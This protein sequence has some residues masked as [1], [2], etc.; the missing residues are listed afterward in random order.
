MPE[1]AWTTT[2]E[3]EQRPPGRLT[4]TISCY[5]FFKRINPMDLQRFAR[6]YRNGTA[7]T[8]TPIEY[9]DFGAWLGDSFSQIQPLVQFTPAEVAPDYFMW[10]WGTFGKLLIS[11]A[12]NWHPIWTRS[13][14]VRFRAVHD[15][16]HLNSGKGFDW[17]GEASAYR[18]AAGT[19]PESIKWILRSEI[20]GQAAYQL[21]TGHFPQQKLVR[22]C[23]G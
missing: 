17:A 15:W 14:N 18:W 9:A 7:S 19:A 5:A 20:L 6:Q 16:H 3:R 12:H 8:L 4:L 1:D 13:E 22:N 21:T 2:P 23:R 11:E 10:H